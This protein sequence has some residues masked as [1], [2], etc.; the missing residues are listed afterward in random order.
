MFQRPC[1][2]TACSLAS[3]RRELDIRATLLNPVPS[4]TS[5]PLLAMSDVPWGSMFWE[6]SEGAG[7][8]SDGLGDAG[9]MW[10]VTWKEVSIRSAVQ[11]SSQPLP[12]TEA[13]GDK[14]CYSWRYRRDEQP[15][16]IGIVTK[17]RQIVSEFDRFEKSNVVE[18]DDGLDGGGSRRRFDSVVFDIDLCRGRHGHE[19]CQDAGYSTYSTVAGS[20]GS[21]LSIS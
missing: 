9:V 10:A 14:W 11:T 8:S 20:R 4:F 18:A 1:R 7:M 21:L 5:Q 13:G 6:F 12:C 19:S 2:N 15:M 16:G 3:L 17:A